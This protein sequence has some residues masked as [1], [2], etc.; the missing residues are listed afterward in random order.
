MPD[1]KQLDSLAALLGNKSISGQYGRTSDLLKHDTDQ[2]GNYDPTGGAK[3]TAFTEGMQ[4]NDPWAQHYE[5]V[6]AL[7]SEGLQYNL[8]EQVQQRGDVF[9]NLMAPVH[10]KGQYEQQIAADKAALDE[11]QFVRGQATQRR[12]Q[13]MAMQRAQGSAGMRGQSQQN[14]ILEAQ[15]K[16]AEKTTRNPWEWLMP[17]AMGGKP[18][19]ADQAA[20]IRAQQQFGAAEGADPVRNAVMQALQT[21]GIDPNLVDE[22]MNDPQA[23]AQLGF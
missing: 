2:F 7:Q 15:A 17:E 18:S 22:I 23:M 20:A 16:A 3:Y 4:K 12:G 5:D 21:E 11:S 6:G 13:D 8:P 14:Q 10:A 19:P 9:M 1:Q